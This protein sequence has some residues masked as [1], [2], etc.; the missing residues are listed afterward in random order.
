MAWTLLILAGVLEAGWAVGLSY[1]EGFT[2]LVPSVLTIGGIALSMGL[3]AIA[4]RQ[5]PI[6][7]AYSVWVGIGAVGATLLGIVL[8]GEPATPARLGFLLLLLVAII[9]LK[10]TDSTP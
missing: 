5:L 9:G 2:R 8:R 6:G 7:T 3:L 10:V 1:T 4:A